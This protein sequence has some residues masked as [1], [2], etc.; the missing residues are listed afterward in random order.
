MKII[1]TAAFPRVISYAN[2]RNMGSGDWSPELKLDVIFNPLFWKDVDN[3]MTAFRL[4][5]A[6][7]E[8]LAK[9]QAKHAE[10][11]AVQ[12]LPP[13][14]SAATTP[15]RKEAAKAISASPVPVSQ[16]R[17]MPAPVSAPVEPPAGVLPQPAGSPRP[18]LADLKRLN[19]VGSAAAQRLTDIGSFMGSRV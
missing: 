14:P 11:I 3:R 2:G 19:A 13:K 17:P 9:I 4:S 8:F 16:S 15:A 12:Q 1:N 5:D 10:E 18:S 7:Q 6:D